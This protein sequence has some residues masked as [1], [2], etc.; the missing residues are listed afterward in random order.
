MRAVYITCDGICNSV[1]DSQ[2]YSF[3]RGLR[4][5]GVD[6]TLVAFSPLAQMRVRAFLEK[7]KAIAD[8][9]DGNAIFL[10]GIPNLG[11]FTAEINAAR[12]KRVVHD[13]FG[14]RGGVVHA[15]GSWASWM[16]IR[17]GARRLIAD[18]RGDQEAE[19]R[20][21]E[22][23]PLITRMKLKGIRRVE[24][25]VCAK[26][27]AIQ[28]V[29]VALADFLVTAR[30]AVRD[31]IQVIPTCVDLRMFGAGA[32]VRAQVRSELALG[33]D[34]VVAY[35]GGAR[36]WNC[37]A[38]QVE[39]FVAVRNLVRNAKFLVITPDAERMRALLAESLPR[40]EWR[41]VSAEHREI[42]RLLAV[43]DLALL[44]REP[45]PVNFVASPTKFSE[46]LASGVPVV[47]SPGIGDTERIVRQWGCGAVWRSDRDLLSVVESVRNERGKIRAACAGAV[48][49]YYDLSFGLDRL[50]AVYAHISKEESG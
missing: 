48:H 9:V 22:N 28:C 10:P 44:I 36:R 19:Y 17:G 47:V 21:Y 31:R 20:L 24:Q 38:K 23:A 6:L 29:S 3:V 46:Y 43:A 49:A 27:A 35:C 40:S 41:V 32:D 13:V 50:A 14:N 1:F 30:G 16:A 26:A 5:R 15:R 34:F 4:D 8:G 7:Q 18:F 25:E 12:L 45:N 42:P 37:P 33:V 2:V 39:A 11:T